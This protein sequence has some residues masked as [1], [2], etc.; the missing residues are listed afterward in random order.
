MNM[1]VNIFDDNYPVF[2]NVSNI[3]C[4]MGE[5]ILKRIIKMADL[6]F[7]INSY[8]RHFTLIYIPFTFNRIL[9]SNLGAH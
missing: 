2:R 5:E 3:L 4:T 6:G 8:P 7:K 1:R 9:Y